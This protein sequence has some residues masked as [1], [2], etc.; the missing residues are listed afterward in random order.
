[1]E[2]TITSIIA[3]VTL[4]LGEIT[5]KFKWINKKFIPYQ[6]LVIGLISGVICYF[7]GLKE[8]IIISIVTCI[9][10]SYSA[11]GIYD[12]I[13]AHKIEEEFYDNIGGEE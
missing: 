9:I 2:L 7:T 12:N 8:N 10:A 3:F 1:M 11:G 5:K 13:T 4:I 6:N